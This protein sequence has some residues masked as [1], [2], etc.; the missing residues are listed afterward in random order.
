MSAAAPG[1][2]PAPKPTV[3]VRLADAA[4]AATCVSLTYSLLLVVL[5]VSWPNLIMEN[6]LAGRLTPSLLLFACLFNCA[7]YM[8]I[9]RQRCLR[10]SPLTFLG[11]GVVTAIAVI[12]CSY[13]LP[14]A[15]LMTQWRAEARVR[16]E[17][18]A[19]VYFAAVAAV[20]FPFLVIRFTQ[21]PQDPE[22]EKESW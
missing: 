16:E 7:L 12:G 11:L 17:V 6:W 21:D 20:F 18:L 4:S 3:K 5:P 14:A 22:Q 1:L 10:T 15:V 9:A 2:A 13:M 19:L 8:N